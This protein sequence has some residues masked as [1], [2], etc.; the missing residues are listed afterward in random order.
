MSGPL[1]FVWFGWGLSSSPHDGPAPGPLAGAGW[2]GCN[3]PGRSD[4]ISRLVWVGFVRRWRG[5]RR[6]GLV[7]EVQ[8]PGASS[9]RSRVRGA[10]AAYIV[11]RLDFVK[12]KSQRYQCIRRYAGLNIL[13]D[14]RRFKGLT[15]IWPE[16]CP[17]CAREKIRS[18]RRRPY[19]PHDDN[20]FSAPAGSALI[21]RTVCLVSL[22]ARAISDAPA[23][24]ASMSAT[25]AYASRE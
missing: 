13:C 3:R 1:H 22:A 24:A 19:S 16:L 17:D 14:P 18:G 15:P 11:H 7:F 2:H 23:P 9:R 10:D 25:T 20:A 8:R 5:L 12:D 4:R 6:G 21:R